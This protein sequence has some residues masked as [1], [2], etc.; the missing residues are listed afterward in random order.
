MRLKNVRLQ[1]VS[2]KCE[3]NKS[4]SK[5]CEIKKSESRL[6]VKNV[7]KKSERKYVRVKHEWKWE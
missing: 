2:I 5:K 7:S 6:W 1:Y 4:E 3:S